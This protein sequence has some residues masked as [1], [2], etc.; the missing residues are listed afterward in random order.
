M[1]KPKAQF[2]LK[3]DTD[4][5]EWVVVVTEFDVGWKRNEDRCY[6]TCDRDDAVATMVFMIEEEERNSNE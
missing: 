4:T 5:G 3:Q 1:R 6:Y 2:R